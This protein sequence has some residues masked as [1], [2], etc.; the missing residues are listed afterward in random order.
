MVIF[1]QYQN[2][3][4]LFY[5]SMMDSFLLFEHRK[6]KNGNDREPLNFKITVTPEH[7]NAL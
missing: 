2:E 5:F 4:H 3:L 1:C 7:S 6:W